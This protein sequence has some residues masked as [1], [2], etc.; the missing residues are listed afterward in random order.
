MSVSLRRHTEL[1]RGTTPGALATS[2]KCAW[3][4]GSRMAAPRAKTM[5]RDNPP[6]SE[7]RK[8]PAKTKLDSRA[9][10]L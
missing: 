8:A 1:A 10:V 6:P 9:A 4:D 2:T 3:A 5:T 7:L